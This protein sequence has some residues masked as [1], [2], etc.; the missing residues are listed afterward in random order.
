[1]L[2]LASESDNITAV[3]DTSKADSTVEELS[4]LEE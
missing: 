4:L 1:M 3:P 2:L